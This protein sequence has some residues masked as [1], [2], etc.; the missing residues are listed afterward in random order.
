MRL[1][2]ILPTLTAT[3]MAM[4]APA[5]REPS[6]DF[7]GQMLDAHN[8]FRKQHSADPLVWDDKLATKALNWAKG[9]QWG[10]SVSWRRQF[11]IP[12]RPACLTSHVY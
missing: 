11:P 4:A 5:K 12:R 7:K 9:C 2:S 1:S 3:G 10:H 8:F 6:G